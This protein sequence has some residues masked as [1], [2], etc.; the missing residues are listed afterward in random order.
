MRK[1]WG[2]EQT[3]DRDGWRGAGSLSPDPGGAGQEGSVGKQSRHDRSWRRGGSRRL[4]G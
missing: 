4:W 1:K 2:R 3:E